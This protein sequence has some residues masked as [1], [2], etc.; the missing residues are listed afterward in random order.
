MTRREGPPPTRP[1][2]CYLCANAAVYDVT[3]EPTRGERAVPNYPACGKHAPAAMQELQNHGFA[4][5]VR[6]LRV[7]GRIQTREER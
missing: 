6:R 2:S 3:A 7:A 5:P 4:E 1:D